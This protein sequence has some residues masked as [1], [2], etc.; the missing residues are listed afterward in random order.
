MNGLS[1]EW[2]RRAEE[3]ARTT[4]DATLHEAR[5]V[6]SDGL[7]L[8]GPTQTTELLDSCGLNILALA[9]CL[10]PMPLPEKFKA[11]KK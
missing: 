3:V 7:R 1:T 8:L 6:I 9:V 5:N 4:P 10:H 2:E 11:V